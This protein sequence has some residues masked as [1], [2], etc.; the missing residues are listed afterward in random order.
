MSLPRD[1]LFGPSE[2]GAAAAAA[3]LCALC[4]L[5]V[6]AW[7]LSYRCSRLLLQGSFRPSSM[8]SFKCYRQRRC[9]QVA[10]GEHCH[11]VENARTQWPNG[12]KVRRRRVAVAP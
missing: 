8:T 9:G 4:A 11:S 2:P 12:S 5:F 10:V 6:C 1:L 7:L 3:R